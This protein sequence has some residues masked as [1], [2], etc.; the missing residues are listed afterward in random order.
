[1][2][3]NHIKFELV[4]AYDAGL[5][6]CDYKIPAPASNYE[7]WISTDPNGFNSDLTSKN[8]SNNSKIK[9]VIR[10]I[11]YWNTSNGK[12]FTSYELEKHIISSYFGY[13]NT[14]LKEYFYDA[15]NS[16]IVDCSWPQ[17]KIDKLT[18]FKQSVAEIMSDDNNNYVCIAESNIEKLL[19]SL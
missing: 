15:V 2:S 18:S 12:I 7:D 10:L 13:F 8:T 17:Y 19:A 11:K 16:L 14:S 3:L 4:P 6:C 9:P 5:Y 1:M